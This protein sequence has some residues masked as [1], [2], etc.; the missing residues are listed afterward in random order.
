MADAAELVARLEQGVQE[1][2]SSE[3]W[4]RFLTAQARFHRYSAGN[5]LLILVQRPEATRV[6]G[7]HTWTDLGRHVRHGEHGIAILALRIWLASAN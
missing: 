2:I 3:G 6:A 1:A 5:M 4:R 7:F